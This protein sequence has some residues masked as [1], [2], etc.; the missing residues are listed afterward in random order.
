MMWEAQAE[1]DLSGCSPQKPLSSL[2]INQAETAAEKSSWQF[3]DVLKKHRKERYMVLSYRNH[4][5][6]IAEELGVSFMVLSGSH[7]V[8]F[9]P[10]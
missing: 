3:E 2:S 1:Q 6:V 8:C 7:T 10:L 5:S 4:C 9:I